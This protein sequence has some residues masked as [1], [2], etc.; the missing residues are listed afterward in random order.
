MEKLL[1]TKEGNEYSTEKYSIAMTFGGS[2]RN[3]IPYDRK[4]IEQMDVIKLIHMAKENEWTILDLSDYGIEQLPDELWDVTTLKVL[5][6]GNY[7]DD[8]KLNNRFTEISDKI[9]NLENLQALSICNVANVIIPKTLKQMTNLVYLDCFGCRYKQIPDSLLN[10]NLKAIGID[11]VDLKELIKICKLKNMEELYLTGASIREVPREIGELKKLRRLCIRGTQVG[12]IPETMLMLTNLKFFDI[13]NTPLYEKIPA[14]MNKQTAKALIAY[15]W[16]QQNENE[17]YYFNESKMIVVGQGNVGKSCLVERITNNTYEEKDSTEGI[18]VKKWNYTK[19]GKQYVLNI[20]DFGG[21][22]IYHSTHQFFLTKRSLYI[23][24]W[25]ARAEEEYGRVDYWL[26]TIE[27]FA[28]ESPII[29][30]INKCDSKITRV[31]RIDMKEYVLK[32]PQIKTVLDISCKDNINIER[33]RNW[34]KKEASSL[35]ITK[36]RWL[37]S[38]YEV[39]KEMEEISKTKAHV[40]YDDYL[41]VCKKYS[42]GAEEA[43]SLSKYL[44]DLGIILHYQ[45]DNFLRN[46]VILRPEWATTAVYKILDSQ[47]GVLRNRNGILYFSDLSKI[48]GDCGLYSEDKYIF[49]LKIMEKF[50]LCYKID[51]HKYLVAELLE[52]TS[53]DCPKGWKFEDDCISIVYKYDFMPAGVMTR[54]IVKVHEYIAKIDGKNMCWRKGVFLQH[55]TAYASVIMRESIAVKEI[56]VKISKQ[57]NS[58]CERELLFTIRKTLNDINSTFN[59]IIVEE[60]VPC[61]CSKKCT[62]QFPYNSLCAALEKGVDTIQ[63]YNSFSQVNVLNLLEGIDIMNKQD[64]SPYSISIQNNPVISNTVSVESSVRQENAVN[65]FEIRNGV[66][67]IQGDIAEI[68]E[69]LKEEQIENSEVLEAQLERIK[70][71]L[72][73]V[74]DMNTPEDIVKSGKLN[75]LKRLLLEFAD[76]TSEVRRSITGTKNI[77]KIIGGILVK[78]NSLAEKLGI[79][80]L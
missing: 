61:N 54:F 15:I 12:K 38:W 62:Y 67:E 79:S 60:F 16:K 39:R 56:Q 42:V 27:S 4:K 13:E 74:G 76:E 71:D 36:E 26:K 51:K 59:K 78:F 49:L 68:Q 32:Y 41:E 44:H 35:Q 17:Q 6:I 19:G 73:Y 5:Y 77:V 72:D 9:V 11:C 69:E 66:M 34:I 14:E 30:A 23:L 20:W 1:S 80:I 25:D 28:N 48:W 18:D 58:L 50:E 70:D 52:N 37:K 64:M 31:N 40:S 22:E 24:V 43:K 33:M 55:K 10:P 75:K 3:V 8:E 2:R 46:I 65:I 45:D 53:V 57:G 63:C 47:E 21:Q 29:I 7:Q